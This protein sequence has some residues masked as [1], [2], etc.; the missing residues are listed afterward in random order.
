MAA[1]SEAS[2][3][4]TAAADELKMALRTAE[5]QKREKL[6]K[7]VGAAGVNAIAMTKVE[8]STH[9]PAT[10]TIS[11]TEG[12]KELEKLIKFRGFLHE[13]RMAD[14]CFLVKTEKGGLV[15]R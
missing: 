1:L 3:S 6:L 8:G 14:E 12:E 10:E 11:D 9:R 2:Q 5:L 13:Q 4:H 15:G 7:R